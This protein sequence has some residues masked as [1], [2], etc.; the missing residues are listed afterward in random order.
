[1]LKCTFKMSMAYRKCA[2]P[3]FDLQYAHV[4]NNHIVPLVLQQGKSWAWFE[5]NVCIVNHGRASLKMITPKRPSQPSY[6]QNSW[7]GVWGT[8]QASCS[9]LYSMCSEYT[10]YWVIYAWLSSLISFKT[11]R[12]VMRRILTYLLSCNRRG[13]GY[14][15]CRMKNLY[16]LALVSCDQQKACNI[17]YIDLNQ[18]QG[19]KQYV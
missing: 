8:W 10:Y 9:P 14:D 11:C 13:H 7:H 4:Q 16:N 3:S 15:L 2:L 1:M 6:F 19:S 12:L 17:S 5:G 18:V